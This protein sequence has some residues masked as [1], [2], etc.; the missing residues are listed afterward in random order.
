M[1]TG[2]GQIVHVY[3]VL[4]ITH[5]SDGTDGLITAGFVDL[6]DAE[7]IEFLVSFGTLESSDSAG[8]WTVSVLATST[9][10]AAGAAIGWIYNLSGAAGADTMGGVTAVVS[11]DTLALTSDATNCVLL[12][13]VD[14]S[15]VASAG[16]DKRYVYITCQSDT[17]DDNG[18]TGTMGINAAIQPRHRQVTMTP[19]TA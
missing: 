2:I 7:S 19:T 3:P 14:P 8:L 17:A 12:V 9:T 16:A 1:P 6:F 10:T 15:V 5:T 4:G 11:T 13:H 18:P